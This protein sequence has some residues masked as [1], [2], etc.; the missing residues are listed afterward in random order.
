[1]K[2]ITKD[3]RHLFCGTVIMGVGQ[4]GNIHKLM[5]K[6]EFDGSVHKTEG[7]LNMN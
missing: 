7:K 1:M 4:C 6:F 2:L 5:R 3:D